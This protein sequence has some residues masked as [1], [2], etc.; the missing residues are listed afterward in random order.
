ME[1]TESFIVIYLDLIIKFNKSLSIFI[2][3][4]FP[5]KNMVYLWTFIQMLFCVIQ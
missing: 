4:I 1:R 5:S 2:P 3:L